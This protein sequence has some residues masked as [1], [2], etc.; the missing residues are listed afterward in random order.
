[1]PSSKIGMCK[2][3]QPFIEWIIY[4]KRPI[5]GTPRVAPYWRFRESTP[6]NG[7]KEESPP[8]RDSYFR[9]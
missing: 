6:Y 1:M 4:I 2:E 5:A 8:K 9:L 3:L 7:L